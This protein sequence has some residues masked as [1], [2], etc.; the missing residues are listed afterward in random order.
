MERGMKA[1]FVLACTGLFACS[2][3]AEPGEERAPIGAPQDIATPPQ[4]DPPAARPDGDDRARATNDLGVGIP[5]TA[6]RPFACQVGAFCDD[7]EALAEEPIGARWSDIVRNGGGKMEVDM[8]SASV[9][10]NALTLFT[11]DETSSAFL[12]HS[13]SGGLVG[14][15]SGVVGFALKVAAVP[16]EQLGGPELTLR[17]GEGHMSIRVTL[18]REGLMLEQL[19]PATCGRERCRPSS[20][21]LAP[22]KEGAWYRVRFTVDAGPQAAP[23]YGRIGATVDGG[24]LVVAPLT[25]PLYDGTASL[26]AGVTQGDTRRALVNVDDVTLLVR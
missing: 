8:E 5:N 17:T 11:P 13:R 10:K 19:A 14:I 18:R 2:A 1:L 25:V 4:A 22:A 9:G 3:A 16:A 26:R 23:P 24:P 21:L 15:W 20:T 12:D 6:P 7:F